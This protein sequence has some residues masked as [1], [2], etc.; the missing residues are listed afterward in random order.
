MNGRLDTLQYKIRFPLSGG[1][2]GG[3]SREKGYGRRESKE[4]EAGVFQGPEAGDHVDKTSK[5]NIINYNFNI[6][7][8]FDLHIASKYTNDTNVLAKSP[9]TTKYAQNLE[10]MVKY[11]VYRGTSTLTASGLTNNCER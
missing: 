2:Q 4:W 5:K 8:L 1:R 11:M 10:I 7:M 9:P 3:G 6:I